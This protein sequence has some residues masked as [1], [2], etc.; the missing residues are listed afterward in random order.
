LPPFL[1]LFFTIFFEIIILK[2]ERRQS[3]DISTVS[4]L[5]TIWLLYTASKGIGAWI[6]LKSTMEEGSLPDR[7]FLL[8]IG[9]IGILILLKRSFNWKQAFRQTR[10]F[11]IILSY[12]LVSVIWSKTPDISLRR[13][14]RESIALIIVWLVLS[15]KYPSKALISI[16]RRIFYIGLPFSILL[17]KYFGEYGR[18]YNRWTG[19][20]MWIGITYHKNGLA[21]FCIFGFMLFVWLAYQYLQK[22]A[23]NRNKEKLNFF[24]DIGMIFLSIYILLGPQKTFSYSVTS[25]I[26]LLLGLAF[27]GIILLAIKSNRALK[28]SKLVAVFCTIIIIGSMLPFSNNIPILKEIPKYFNRDSTLTGR[29]KIWSS[30]V[31][32]A[33]KHFLLGYGMGGFW[34]TSLRELIAPHAHNGYLDA[35]LNFGLIGLIAFVIFYLYGAIKQV[36]SI[37]YK[38]ET[39]ILFLAFI[40]MILVH[41]FTESDFSEISKFPVSSIILCINITESNK[42]EEYI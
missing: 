23:L 42:K 18:L 25:N 37:N 31:P 9:L 26:T 10:P 8:I 24:I 36:N 32:Y 5:P 30:L 21:R 3:Y 39:A 13:W 6:N 12:M 29:T 20:V 27:L 22:P 7:I 1:A 33:K 34:T 4:W 17:I 11:I 41:N 35:I 2:I 19:E 15:E 16:F 14:V 40:F 28:P 38:E